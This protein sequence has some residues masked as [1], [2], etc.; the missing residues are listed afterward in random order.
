MDELEKPCPFCGHKSR[1]TCTFTAE[2]E[3]GGQPVTKTGRGIL[4]VNCFGIVFTEPYS[5]EKEQGKVPL[6]TPYTYRF[7]LED[8]EAEHFYNCPECERFV[9]NNVDNKRTFCA[10]CGQKLD[11]TKFLGVQP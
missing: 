9:S 7:P 11:W 1:A 8:K 3:I 6:Y 5:T 10:Y 2:G 4:C